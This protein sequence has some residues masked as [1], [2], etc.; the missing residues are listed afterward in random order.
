VIEEV[1][2]AGYSTTTFVVDP[3][4]NGASANVSIRTRFAVRPGF[5]GAI[6]RL[7]TVSVL[8]RIFAKELVLLGNYAA[9]LP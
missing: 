5:F 6:E 8:R 3:A 2:A 1:D 7:L 9:T 4:E